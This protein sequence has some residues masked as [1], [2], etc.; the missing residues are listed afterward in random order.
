MFI[1]WHICSE[2]S[3]KCSPREKDLAAGRM[4]VITVISVVLLEELATLLSI[5]LWICV[6]VYVCVCGLRMFSHSYRSVLGCASA[7]TFYQCKSPSFMCLVTN[8]KEFQA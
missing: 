4:F 1:K 8:W 6:H 7:P 2:F 3:L 5:T